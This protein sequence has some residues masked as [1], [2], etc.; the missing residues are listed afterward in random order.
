MHRASRGYR[1]RTSRVL[2]GFSRF[3]I[4]PFCSVGF[5]F[6]SY[7]RIFALNLLRFVSTDRGFSCQLSDIPQRTP[8]G[9]CYQLVCIALYSVS[10]ATYFARTQIN[11]LWFSD[12][13]FSSALHRIA[14]ILRKVYLVPLIILSYHVVPQVL[15]CLPR[16]FR[17]PEPFKLVQHVT[18]WSFRI[19]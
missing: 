7:S 13:I 10:S 11:L 2:R 16:L 9:V 1:L 8:A 19:L 3:M 12:T 14:D 6:D 4:Y 15:R 17:L 18:C 5:L